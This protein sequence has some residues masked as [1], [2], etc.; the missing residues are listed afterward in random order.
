MFFANKNIK[1]VIVGADRVTANGDVANKIGTYSLAVLARYHGVK[2]MVVAPSSTVDMELKTGA[3][4]EIEMRTTQELT[5]VAGLQVAPEGVSAI[6]PVFDVTPATLIDAI[7]TEKGV[8]ENPNTE[9]M[10]VLFG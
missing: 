5:E 2:V 8:I 7:V 6:N 9:K 1:W 3:E 4:I 10:Q